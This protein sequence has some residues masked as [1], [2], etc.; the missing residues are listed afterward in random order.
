MV[1]AVQKSN[2]KNKSIASPSTLRQATHTINRQDAHAPDRV[3]AMKAVEDKNA[4]DVIVGN[5]H[6]FETIVHA[7]ID[8]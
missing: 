3:Y 2:K 5:F 8:P 4:L 1:L 6:M 7:L